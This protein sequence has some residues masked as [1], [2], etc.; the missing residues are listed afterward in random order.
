MSTTVNLDASA[1][2]TLLNGS[3]QFQPALVYNGNYGVLVSATP[4]SSGTVGLAINASLLDPTGAPMGSPIVVNS[5][6]LTL[7]QHPAVAVDTDGSFIVA[8]TSNTTIELQRFSATGDAIG[9]ATAVSG[10]KIADDASIAYTTDGA[11]VVT[12][13]AINGTQ[14]QDVYGQLY[15][16]AGVASGAAFVVNTTTAGNQQNARVASDAAGDFVVAWQGTS[17]A[18]LDEIYDQRFTATGTRVGSQ[19]VVNTTVAGNQ[20]DPDIAVTPA[21]SFIVSWD[22]NSITTTEIDF[23]Q[24]DSSGVANGPQMVASTPGTSTQSNPAVAIRN[25]GIFGIAWLNTANLTPTTVARYYLPDGTPITAPVTL[26]EQGESGSRPGFA[27]VP[28]GVTVVAGGTSVAGVVT[29]D[30][31]TLTPDLTVSG[32]PNIANTITGVFSTLTLTLNQNGSTETIPSAILQN[33]DIEGGNMANTISIMG[34]ASSWNGDLL[35]DGNG[36]GDMITIGDLA[37]VQVNGGNGNDTITVGSGSDSVT[38]GGGND[39][40]TGG[41]G[42]DVLFGNDGNDTILSG[43]GASILDGGNGDDTLIAN[44]AGE[45]LN[46]DAG[47]DMLIGGSGN[48][49]LNGGDGNDTI[50]GGAGIDSINGGLGNDLLYGGQGG[51]ATIRGG[52]GN[53][54]VTF[55]LDTQPVHVKLGGY[56]NNGVAGEND[57]IAA[58][59]ANAIGG[60]G[61]DTLIANSGTSAIY[62]GPGN[63]M[64]IAGS[65]TD[66]LDGNAGN[67]TLVAGTGAD[68]FIG[69][70]GSDTVS[71]ANQSGAL[72]LNMDG[73]PDSGMKGQR[74]TIGLS[75]ENLIGGSGTDVITG[76]NFSNVIIVGDGTDTVSGMS[77][78]DTITAG[79]GTDNINGGSGND[80]I[81]GGAGTDS[82]SGGT[83]NDVINGGAGND[84][85]HGNTGNDTL[86]GGSGT[87]FLY[88]DAGNDTLLTG[89]GHTILNGGSGN[90]VGTTKSGD[91]VTLIQKIK[92]A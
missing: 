16:S 62:G 15:T 57:F 30:I 77:G 49:T 39:S 29:T 81:I 90:N 22:T 11:F 17:G 59:V 4:G 10:S 73:L 45:L 60:S 26:S 7:D 25:D 71:F 3:P 85:L 41:A 51:N 68:N 74:S 64:L 1:V 72:S 84:T 56:S 47:N 32:T 37:D 86:I 87:D 27:F 50:I 20:A 36:T 21:G 38:G 52:G 24:Y 58:D 65:G 28:S 8:W 82:L 54:T 79:S 69:A 5:P 80:S 83:G 70:S 14:L 63:D 12:Y 42:S 61:N 9:T 89:T 23:Q 75:I 53:D 66:L 55:V 18:N 78:N 67:D 92:R 88:G 31:Q 44:N 2:Q 33:I 35:V 76:S 19:T 6:Q 48:D 46:G 40:I 34:T 43:S 13:Q 91:I